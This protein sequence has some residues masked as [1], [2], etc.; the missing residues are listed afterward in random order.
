M[1][2]YLS[3]TL[4]SIGLAEGGYYQPHADGT[5]H[6]RLAV[7]HK[8]DNRELVLF[9]SFVRMPDGS[10]PH[11]E[12][13]PR[14]E[15]VPE[16]EYASVAHEVY[17]SI[18]T[19]TLAEITQQ[20]F[21]RVPLYYIGTQ[22]SG[23]YWLP[24]FRIAPVPVD[25]EHPGSGNL[26]RCVYIDQNVSA[27]DERL[28]RALAFERAMRYAA[29]L[30]LILDVGLYDA[31]K[32]YVWIWNPLGTPASI[33]GSRGYFV[34]GMRPTT[35]MPEKGVE[36]PLGEFAWS[37]LD[38]DI[39][40]GRNQAGFLCCRKETR[41]ILRGVENAPTGI[42]EAFD[43]CSR[44]YQLSMVV[45]E[46]FPTVRVAYQVAAVD[47]LSQAGGFGGFTNFMEQHVSNASA[48]R[49]F[50]DTLYSKVRSSHFHGGAFPLG[51]FLSGLTDAI[52]PGPWERVNIRL[53]G[54]ALIREAI[55]RWA[56]QTL[57]A[58]T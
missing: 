15:N 4:R 31:P 11:I 18:L 37:V 41:V 43:S 9:W 45:G 10:I 21:Q 1:L 29:R 46:R 2:E 7:A 22:L 34:R 36:A 44:L 50:L 23:E 32:E 55:F 8:Q 35:S 58:S 42:Q 53:S 19:A 5:Y 3:A 57:P 49:T 47:A 54:H 30:S 27:I 39:N 40:S 52:D 6:V 24:G 38:T 48:L 25:D 26:E 28:A 33:R 12:V 56:T 13:I 14:D 16:S 51:D 20:F 17:N